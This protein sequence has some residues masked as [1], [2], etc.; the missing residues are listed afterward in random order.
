MKDSENG[1]T[2][3]CKCGSIRYRTAPHTGNAYIC[4]CTFCQRMTGG[5]HLV[6]HCFARDEVE[7]VR[8]TPAVYTHRSD[9]SGKEVYLHFCP[10]CGT[11]LYLTLERWPETLN[12]FTT[13][14]DDPG[15]V[16]FGPDQLRYLFL[17][18]AQSGTVTPAGYKAYDGHCDRADGTSAHEHIFEGH[19]VNATI[20]EGSGP[21][22]GGCLCGEVQFAA[23]GEPDF[24][25]IC[26][27]RSCQRALGSEMNFELLFDPSRFRVTKGE[28]RIYRHSGGSGKMLEK[29]FCGTCGTSLYLTGERFTEVGVFRGA[30]DRPNRVTVTPDSAIQIC[31]D[32]ALPSAVVLAGIESFHQ[33]RR[34]PDGTIN[35]GHTFAEPWRVGDRKKDWSNS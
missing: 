10:E 9:G 1:H 12:I 14:L 27:C 13:T 21:H 8:G 17:G 6:E 15:E 25:V 32:E 24:I 28:P 18:S 5:P 16:G 31:L 29:R 35:S 4:N 7:I 26:H 20:D 30:L 3:G 19:R 11:H 33:H 34:A 22:T 23:N 2:G